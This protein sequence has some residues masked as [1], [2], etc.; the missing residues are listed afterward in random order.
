LQG[1]RQASI[2]VTPSSQSDDGTFVFETPASSI[3]SVASPQASR[4]GYD[5]EIPFFRSS[6]GF[7]ATGSPRGRVAPPRPQTRP[8]PRVLQSAPNATADG[9]DVD[10]DAGYLRLLNKILDAARRAVFPSRGSFNMS[11]IL[12][13]LPGDGTADSSFSYES[14]GFRSKSRLER[15]KKIG[16][17]GEL[18]VSL[19][20]SMLPASRCSY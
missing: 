15:D 3:P 4:S 19:Y 8:M 7:A 13:A 11:D 9:M 5:N 20:P 6:A 12:D 10:M 17:A 2:P 1:G 14:V 16:A 18:F